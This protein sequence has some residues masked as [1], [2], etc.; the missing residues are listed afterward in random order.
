MVRSHFGSNRQHVVGLAMVGWPPLPPL[1]P[2]APVVIRPP[3]PASRGCNAKAA[4]VVPPPQAF[5]DGSRVLGCTAKTKAAVVVPPPR[6]SWELSAWHGSE[7]LCSSWAGSAARG[8]SRSPAA[9]TLAAAATLAVA[10]DLAAA[11]IIADGPPL[12]TWVEVPAVPKSAQAVIADT[13]P[14]IPAFPHQ[15]HE[16]GPRK[17]IVIDRGA[18]VAQPVGQAAAA[19]DLTRAFRS[20]L[21][22]NVIT[23]AVAQ[24]PQPGEAGGGLL[25]REPG[26]DQTVKPSPEGYVPVP[27]DADFWQWNRAHAAYAG[28]SDYEVIGTI[29]P[30][31]HPDQI[32]RARTLCPEMV[33]TRAGQ[34]HLWSRFDETQWQ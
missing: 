4:V 14:Q 28:W 33:E 26:P 24:P 20:N 16:G 13:I 17:S 11:A 22:F 1:P 18:L 5:R 25:I 21:C 8:R 30:A 6:P 15:G 27:A 32:A 31:D 3:S 9:T 34:P 23:A 29:W 12:R 10:A 19:S 7:W 2:P